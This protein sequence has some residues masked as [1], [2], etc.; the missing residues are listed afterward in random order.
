MTPRPKRPTVLEIRLKIAALL[1]VKAE[2]KAGYDR[3]D[4]L[5]DELR[6]ALKVGRSIDMG[7][8]ET[9]VI[10]DNFAEKNVAW[11]HGSVRRFDLKVSKSKTA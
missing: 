7:N 9:A 6:H 1:M 2:A 3:C 4:V 10:V 5:L 11:G 8:G